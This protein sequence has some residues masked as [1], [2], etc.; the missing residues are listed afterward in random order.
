MKWKTRASKE[1]P[2]LRQEMA[3][4]EK[5]FGQAKKGRKASN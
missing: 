3:E 5:E 1:E 2:Q 4:L